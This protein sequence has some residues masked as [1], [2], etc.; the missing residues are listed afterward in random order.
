M[1]AR[2][3]FEALAKGMATWGVC[4]KFQRLNCWTGPSVTRD[5]QQAGGGPPKAVEDEDTIDRTLRSSLA[6]VRAQPAS[7]EERVLAERLAERIVA[8]H[9][10][11]PARSPKAPPGGDDA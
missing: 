5:N 4:A 2:Q 1:L 9:E 11:K 7:A 3:G 8:A 6:E 10:R